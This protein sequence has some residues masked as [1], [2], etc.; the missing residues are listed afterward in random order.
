[1]GNWKSGATYL[2]ETAG[3]YPWPITRELPSL[4]WILSNIS[5]YYFQIE[6]NLKGGVFEKVFKKSRTEPVGRVT[7]PNQT[8]T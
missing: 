8:E 4:A 5:V 6:P 2:P 1:V 7:C 3:T